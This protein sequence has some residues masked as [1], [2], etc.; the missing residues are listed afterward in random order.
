MKTNKF[1]KRFYR[2]WVKAKDLY[3]SRVVF[4]ETDLEILTDK[5]I[6]EK[7]V[8][9]KIKFYRWQIESYID[10]D[11][12]FL[13]AL[14]P[15]N[16]E[17]NA[18]LVVK[19]MAKAAKAA[20][21]GPMA[22][23]AGAI[24]QILGKDLLK[25]GFKEVII[26]NGGDLFLK[27]KKTRTVGIYPGKS[28]LWK[29]LKLKIKPN[30]APIGICTSSGTVGHSLSFGLADSV[31]ILA[32]D[33]A[34]ADAVATATCNRVKSADDLESSLEFAKSIKG[35]TAVVIILKNNLISWGKIE[36]TS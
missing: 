31:V 3:T 22:T 4:K 19:E 27:S 2:D 35:I 36:F 9:E 6:D 16:V 28:E 34:L 1:Q 21:V 24:A 26:E 17:I 25:Q 8:R 30:N 18:P 7:F 23:V 32:K 20:G 11:K 29:G 5:A 10:K 33:A 15:I 13:T 12:R 14:K